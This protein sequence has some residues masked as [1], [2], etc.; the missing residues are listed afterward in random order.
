MLLFLSL[1]AHAE[2]GLLNGVLCLFILL[3]L[4]GI[5]LGIIGTLIELYRT[6]IG[7]KNQRARHT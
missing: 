2:L 6:H 5:G 7:Q 3:L 4:L 1:K